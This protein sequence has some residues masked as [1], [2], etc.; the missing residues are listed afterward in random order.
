[1]PP[2]L[3]SVD[4]EG[5]Y[6]EAFQRVMNLP[7]TAL[8]TSVDLGQGNHPR[9]KKEYARRVCRVALGLA[10]DYNLEYYGPFRVISSGCYIL[11]IIWKAKNVRMPIVLSQQQFLKEFFRRIRKLFC[12]H[13]TNYSFK[14]EEGKYVICI[15]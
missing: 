7:N 8:A 13:K 3:D 11:E 12:E 5:M 9:D 14:F 10:C 1:M 6:S 15:S 2:P 4:N